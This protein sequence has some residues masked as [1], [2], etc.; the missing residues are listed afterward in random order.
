MGLTLY[1]SYSLLHLSGTE[2][3]LKLC[4]VFQEHC[5]KFGDWLS[6]GEEQMREW[7]LVQADLDRLKE[8]E[9]HLEVHVTLS[10]TTGVCVCVCVSV[11]VYVGGSICFIS[12]VFKI[13]WV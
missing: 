5:D 1:Y 11:S 7:G 2:E 6:G 13:V 12:Y 9:P 8:Q 3:V 4:E 10:L